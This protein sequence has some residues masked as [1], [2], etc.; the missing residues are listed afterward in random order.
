MRTSLKWYGGGSD[1]FNPAL[2]AG[3]KLGTEKELQVQQLV[4]CL[5]VLASYTWVCYRGATHTLDFIR[6]MAQT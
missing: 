4:F 3:A 5:G 6:D 1:N 2:R